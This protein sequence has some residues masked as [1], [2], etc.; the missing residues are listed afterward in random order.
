M[1]KQLI[2]KITSRIIF[3]NTFFFVKKARVFNDNK[4]IRSSNPRRIYRFGSIVLA[5]EKMQKFEEFQYFANFSWEFVYF[6]QLGNFMKWP[7]SSIYPR[8]ILN[9]LKSWVWVC[10]LV[11][12]FWT[13]WSIMRNFKRRG[14]Y[15]KWSPWARQLKFFSIFEIFLN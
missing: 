6:R 8:R 11:N 7:S 3:K 14:R 9:F 15:I 10:L 13:F 1:K 4:R 5:W 12:N 2:F